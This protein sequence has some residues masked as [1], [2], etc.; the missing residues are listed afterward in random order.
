MSSAKAIGACF[1][2]DRAPC[3]GADAD[4]HHHEV[5]RRRQ[6]VTERGALS[7]RRITA[8]PALL[9]GGPLPPGHGS[10][11]VKTQGIDPLVGERRG[12][13]RVVMAVADEQ[14]AAGAFGDDKVDTVPGLITL[15]RFQSP[16]QRAGQPDDPGAHNRAVER[17]R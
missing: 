13:P 12:D 11:L 4:R 10:I 16:S 1:V 17:A 6:G 9:N 15:L 14:T 5:D 7:G 3:G 2:A 8:S